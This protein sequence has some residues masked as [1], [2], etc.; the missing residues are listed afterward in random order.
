M[1]RR[2]MVED[3]PPQGPGSSPPGAGA[4][5]AWSVLSYLI[6]G[7]AVWGLTGWL[8]DRWLGLDGLATAAGVLGGAAGGMYLI[9]RRLGV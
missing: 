9:I 8:V 1:V 7:M 3:Q 6:A 4:H 5:H 2:V